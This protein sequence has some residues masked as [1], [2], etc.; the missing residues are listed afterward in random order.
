MC[1]EVGIPCCLSRHILSADFSLLLAFLLS[2]CLFLSLDV[3][4]VQVPKTLH[5]HAFGVGRSNADCG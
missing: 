2:I 5:F 3:F 4:L 1:V